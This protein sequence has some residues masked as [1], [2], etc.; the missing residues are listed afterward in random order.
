MIITCL[1]ESAA[2]ERALAGQPT[3]VQSSQPHLKPPTAVPVVSTPVTVAAVQKRLREAL[4]RARA[5]QEI[6]TAQ[7]RKVPLQTFIVVLI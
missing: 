3:H 7:L 6:H 5:E 4:V 2:D 1:V